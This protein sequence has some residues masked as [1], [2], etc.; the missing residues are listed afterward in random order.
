MID[1]FLIW[2]LVLKSRINMKS[3]CS[4]RKIFPKFIDEQ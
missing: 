4:I 2:N 1:S 3:F